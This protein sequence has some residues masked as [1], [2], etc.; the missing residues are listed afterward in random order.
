MQ[1]MRKRQMINKVY[2]NNRYLNLSHLETPI[3]EKKTYRHRLQ[4]PRAELPM[5]SN[6]LNNYIRTKIKLRI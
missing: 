2:N 5:Q 6:F 1:V 4:I 3:K